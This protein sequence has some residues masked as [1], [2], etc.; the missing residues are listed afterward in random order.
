[1]NWSTGGMHWSTGVMDWCGFEWIGELE[2]CIGVHLNGVEHCSNGLEHW[3]NG[4]E[5]N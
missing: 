3:F 1:M 4:L 5:W 2:E